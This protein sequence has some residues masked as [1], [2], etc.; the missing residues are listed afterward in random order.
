M[1][2]P[3]IIQILKSNDWEIRNG[4]LMHCVGA[5]LSL[6]GKKDFE[7][8]KNAENESLISWT[9]D[10]GKVTIN[11]YQADNVAKLRSLDGDARSTTEI[12]VND[13]VVFSG[14]DYLNP[15][16]ATGNKDYM[17]ETVAVAKDSPWLVEM[18]THHKNVERQKSNDNESALGM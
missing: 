8:S 2:A 7:Y 9:S 10:N 1:S 3:S 12:V 17:K 5:F 4:Q 11:R 14:G 18:Y 6:Y 13:E 16:V 15:L